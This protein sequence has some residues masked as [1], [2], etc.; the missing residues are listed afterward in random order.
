[1]SKWI[2]LMIGLIILGSAFT[3]YFLLLFTEDIA[4]Q[5][6]YFGLFI[7]GLVVGLGFSIYALH[8]EEY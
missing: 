2:L 7:I 4:K 6:F 8:K 5:I 3:S 1:M